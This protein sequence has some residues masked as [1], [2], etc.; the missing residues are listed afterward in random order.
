[1]PTCIRMNLLLF[2]VGLL[3]TGSAPSSGQ[4]P[5]PPVPT[6][7]AITIG[8]NLVDP[9]HYAGWSGPLTACEF[10]ARDIAE[11]AN[12]QGFDVTTLLTTEATRSRVATEIENAAAALKAGDIMLIH[13]SGH[14]AYL[15]DLNGDETDAQDETWCLYDG[16]LV[17][18]ELYNLYSKF[19]PGVRVLVLSDSCHSGTVTRAMEASAAL[20]STGSRF[21]EILGQRKMLG[22][23]TPRELPSEEDVVVAEGLFRT[24]PSSLPNLENLPAQV[25]V[26]NR[27]FYDRI[28]E[29][30]GDAERGDLNATVL[31]I[32]GCQDNQ[33]SLDGQFNGLFTGK[34]KRTWDRGRFNGDYRD[35]HQQIQTQMPSTQSPNYYVIGTPNPSFEQE[36]PFSL[37]P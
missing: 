34:L 27:G 12:D 1:M 32:S 19:Q 35:F 33:L 13:Y 11:I 31:L 30:H 3:A 36:K 6:G 4:S 29:E 5:T 28:L 37:K 21:S 15:P 9:G 16:Q 8:L 17:D 26:R 20:A 14:G 2:T 24:M 18:D 7:R 22:L 23:L 10:D 25:Y